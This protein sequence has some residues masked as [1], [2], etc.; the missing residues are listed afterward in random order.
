M[1]GREVGIS[2]FRLVMGF[3]QKMEMK[4]ETEYDP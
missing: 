3:K 1:P 2:F 4:F